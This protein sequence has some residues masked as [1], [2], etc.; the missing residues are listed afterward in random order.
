MEIPKG[1]EVKRLNDISYVLR[2]VSFKGEEALFEPQSGFIPILRANNITS[3]KCI[4]FNDL[5]F[6][7]SKKVKP[8]LVLREGDFIMVASNGNPEL[9]GNYA[10]FVTSSC[11]EIMT[12]GAFLY[13][14]RPFHFLKSFLY[15]Y[16]S[17]PQFKEYITSVVS[18]T[19]I[20]NLKKSDLEKFCLLYPPESILERF[21]SLV[22]PLFQKILLNQKQIMTL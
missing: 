2:G 22:D 12:F 9:V 4:D 7:R 1:W 21:N 15:F 20:T 5:M 3:D 16:L 19:N 13:T 17:S 14:I 10:I 6:V 11:W 18:G 8:E